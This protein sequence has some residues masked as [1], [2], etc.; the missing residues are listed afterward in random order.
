[1]EM[2]FGFKRQRDYDLH[3]ALEV[4]A[5]T[6]QLILRNGCERGIE[7]RG[8]CDHGMID[9]IYFRDPSALGS[10]GAG[11]PLLAGFLES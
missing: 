5:E 4:G 2:P 9:S 6:V 3:V 11:K 10:R 8:P 7:V 1:M